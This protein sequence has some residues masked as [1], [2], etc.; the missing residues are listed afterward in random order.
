MDDLIQSIK[1]PLKV[2]LM[3]ACRDNPLIQQTL[4]TA[5][6]GILSRGLAPPSRTS[7]GLF[8]AYATASGNVAK[9]GVKN[10]NSPFASALAKNLSRPESIDDMFSRVTKEVL[11]NTNNEQRPFKY[12]SLEDKFCL[13]GPCKDLLANYS[14]S[15]ATEKPIEKKENLDDEFLYSAEVVD[16]KYDNLV[17]F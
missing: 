17:F 1:S 14:P 3:D 10:T 8:V 5:S 15:Q 9:D 7:G 12:A 2:V 11:K 16:V 4:S 6:R 13:P